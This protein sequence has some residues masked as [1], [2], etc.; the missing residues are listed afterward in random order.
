MA[1]DPN[2]LKDDIL[3]RAEVVTPIPDVAKPQ[4]TIF[5]NGISICITDQIERGLA[6]VLAGTVASVSGT[7]NRITSSGGINPVIDIS[8]AYDSA[9]QSYANGVANTAESNANSYTDSAIT[10]V[11]KGSIGISI[12]GSGY[13]IAT[14]GQQSIS[15][16]P[17]AGT[18]TGWYLF[19]TSDT[20]IAST[21]VID[22]WKDTYANYPPTVADTIF[23]TKPSLTA[24]TKNTATGL[25][26][27]FSANDI[28]KYNI[29]SNDLA[30]NLQLILLITK[31]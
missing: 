9:V 22:V 17:F 11:K 3:N 25:S 31:T 23:G 4:F 20:P 30:Q 26:I 27:S 1:L 24:V 29:D 28:F 14:G 8:A 7:E 6:E 21:C 18:I 13:V 5:V 12:S 10:N 2:L 19:E 15:M 16:P